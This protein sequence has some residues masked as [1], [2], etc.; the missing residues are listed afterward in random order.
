MKILVNNI[1]SWNIAIFLVLFLAVFTQIN[2]KI[3]EYPLLYSDSYYVE[4]ATDNLQWSLHNMPLDQLGPDDFQNIVTLSFS[5]KLSSSKKRYLKYLW[6]YS[7]KYNVNPFWALAIMKAE[8]GFKADALSHANAYG[9]MQI[10]PTTAD[11]ILKMMGKKV[12]PKILNKNL[13]QPKNNI[14]LGVYYLSWLQKLFK[15]NK[16]LAT[17]GYNMGPYWVKRRLEKSLP[18]GTNNRYLNK[19]QINYKKLLMAFSKWYY[20]NE[21]YFVN[22]LVYRFKVNSYPSSELEILD[23]VMAERYNRA[24]ILTRN[25]YSHNINHSLL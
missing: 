25:I 8:S 11:T 14:K 17:I 1:K 24:I 16:S 7:R 4:Q 2:P 10:M 22:T 13:L 20:Q 19:V 23:K 3:T 12:S 15:W 18:I 6:S 21:N 9:L 5:K